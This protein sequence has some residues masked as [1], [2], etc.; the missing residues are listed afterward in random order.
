MVLGSGPGQSEV[1]SDMHLKFLGW[2][3]VAD[4]PIASTFTL[5]SLLGGGPV[6]VVIHLSW[7]SEMLQLGISV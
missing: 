4:N 5:P 6:R 1:C 2:D 7:T 3:K